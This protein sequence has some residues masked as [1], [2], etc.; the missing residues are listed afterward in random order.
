MDLKEGLDMARRSVEFL[1]R[2]GLREWPV[3]ELVAVGG[4]EGA[5]IKTDELFVRELVGALG[6]LR[7]RYVEQIASLTLEIGGKTSFLAIEPGEET[8]R[9]D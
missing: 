4:R 1:G 2:A 7:I 6:K 3:L 9:E 5:E 8:D